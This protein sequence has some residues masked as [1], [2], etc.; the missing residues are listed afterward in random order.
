MYL[1][2]EPISK[3]IGMYV[4]AYPLPIMEIASFIKF[5]K[6]DV[7]IGI[8]SLSVDYGLP[9]SS[10]GSEKVS[11]EFIDDIIE[12]KPKGIGVSCTAI[13]QAEEAIRISELIKKHDPEIFVFLG[14]YFPTIYHKE[15]FAR[16]TAVDL[17]VVGEGEIPSLMILECLEKKQ[18]PR[19]ENIPNLVWVKNGKPH[20]TK[21]GYRF[22]MKEK[23]PLN[24]NLLR[25]SKKYDILPYSFSRGCPYN[26]NFCME[27]YIRPIRKEVPSDI[28]K[29]DLINLSKTAGSNKLLVCDA[30]FKSFD[31]AP[32][33]RELN[34][35]IRFETRCDV[36]SPS[37]IPEFADICGL[38]VLGFESASYDTLKRMN[39]VRDKE[40]YK[41]YISNTTAIFKEAVNN[42]IPVMVFMIGGYPGDTERD[43]QD[44]L[45]F[46]E[47]LAAYQ[48]PGGHVFKIG[49]CHVY[50][51]TKIYDLA[52]SLPEVV[53][54]NDGVFGQ[55]IVR[56][57]SKDL[58]Y[59]TILEYN[60]E[61]YNLSNN[62]KKLQNG[63]LNMMPFFRLPVIALS[64]DIIP[65]EC[66]KD[67]DKDVFKVYSENLDIFREY[68]PGLLTKY[69]EWSSKERK[70][71]ILPI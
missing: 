16:T 42:E 59:D 49:E 15:I 29:K 71:R 30:L 21:Q 63:F 58:Q 65:V 50:P 68:A 9:L 7:E 70:T 34:M 37:I 45:A 46:A 40:H 38:L 13:S 12:M 3:N 53:F 41:K 27:E 31:I 55:N 28:I 4:S 35:N 67:N 44:S 66:F 17:I 2:V 19:N 23:V 36:L 26:C 52:L 1:F 24:L 8:I 47:K 51:N 54:D 11:K 5:N 10:A 20:F 6:P 69:R 32:L 61:I 14:G 62:T 60:K 64:D 18:D 56:K 48:G 39:K 25:H 43:L 33:I 22:D 57:P